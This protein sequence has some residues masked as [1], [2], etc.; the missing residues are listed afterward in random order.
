MA[1]RAFGVA[2]AILI[3]CGLGIHDPIALGVPKRV[4]VR[5]G[6]VLTA[7]AGMSGIALLGAGGWGERLRVR[8]TRCGNLLGFCVI[9]ACA[10]LHARSLLGTRRGCGLIPIAKIV[11]RCGD[12]SVIGCTVTARATVGLAACVGTIG[13]DV[14]RPFGCRGVTK[15]GYGAEY[16]FKLC[17]ADGTIG[18][19]LVRSLLSAGGGGS[20]FGDRLGCCVPTWLNQ[21]G[22]L[23]VAG[24]AGSL[25]RT[26]MFACGVIS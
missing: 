25:L 23:G 16:S 13:L 2:T 8:V 24:V 5:I 4:C 11:P 20:V 9:T 6:I 7:M 26:R 18:C 14:Y 3:Y 10:M 17:R 19:Q 22:F 15:R 21:L 12:L 1:N